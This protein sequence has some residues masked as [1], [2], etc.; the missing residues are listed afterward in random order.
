MKRYL[1]SRLLQLIPTLFGVITLVFLILHLVP[2]DPVEVM[3][4][5]Q[6][7]AAQKE[8]LRHE[9][10]LDLP[11]FT[12]YFHYLHALSKGDLG[13]SLIGHDR[14]GA[15]IL[16]HLPATLTLTAAAFVWAL[17]LAFP[18]GIFVA[19]RK[20]SFADR[21]AMF[22]SMVGVAMPNFWL[23]PLLI[24][25]FAVSLGWL[26]VSGNEGWL[27]L[28]LPSFTLGSG[29]AALLFQQLRSSF[30]ETLGE[31]YMKTAKAKG[32]SGRRIYL[33]HALLN[34]LLPVVTVFG[35][36]LGGLLA[37]AVITETIFAW[38]GIGRLTI[39]A[40]ETRDYPLVQGCVLFISVSYLLINFLVDLCYSWLDPRIRYGSR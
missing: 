39:E 19:I 2:G 5:E 31:E 1:F 18:L 3:L 8:A 21:F 13:I 20:G 16:S 38:P 27:S 22:F 10:G 25:F 40:I 9:L 35:M 26:P 17:L 7:V 14:V 4:G 23:G 34:A 12:Q 28:L 37:G 6:A 32:L 36:Q 15:E 11:L 33:R 30:I 29:M 24:L